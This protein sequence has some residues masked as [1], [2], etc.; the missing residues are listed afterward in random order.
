M[1]KV[2]VGIQWGDEGKGRASHFE[3]K[4][5]SLVVRSTGGNNAG[6]TVVA[7]GK[8]FAMHLL[9]SSI[10]RD[11]VLSIIGPG[12]VID[13]KVLISEI[14][15]MKE[16]GIN[17]DSKKLLISDRAH[18]I[19]PH[20]IALDSLSEMLKKKKLVQQVVELVLVMLKNVIEQILE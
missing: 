13:P 9:P 17:I 19:L 7:N 11:G 16:T 8:K 1:V 12:V 20:H 5:A 2:I 14:E 4:N 6:H 3:S 15:Q 18:I 10:I